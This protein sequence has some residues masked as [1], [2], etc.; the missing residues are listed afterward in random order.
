M[1]KM[2]NRQG[3]PSVEELA[4][5][6]GLEIVAG[7]KGSGRLIEDGY[8]GDLLSDVMGNAPPGCIWITI[9]GHQNIVAVALLREMAAI[10]IAGGFTP[11]NDTVL[12]ADQEGIPLLRWPG[13]SYELAGKLHAIGIKGEDPDKGK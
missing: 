8:C 12:R 10:V 6:L 2:K 13:S 4:R 9:Q 11:D 3:K 7:E 1:E 5:E